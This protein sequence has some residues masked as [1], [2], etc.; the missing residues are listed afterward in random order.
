MADLMKGKRGLIM[1]VANERSIAWA[2][3]KVLAAEGAEL[4]F[5]YQGEGFG[6]RLRPLAESVGSSLVIPAD[7]QDEA[8]LDA[9]FKTLKDEWGTIDFLVHAIAYS[10]KEELAG[11][12]IDT[13]R[14]NFLNSLDISCFSFVDVAK[15]A[16]ALMPDGGSMITLT[17]MG[18]NR[19]Q[20]NYNVMG[21]AKAA[22]ESSVRYLANDLGPDNIRVNAVSPGPMKTLAGAA[23]GGARKVYRTIGEN[24]PLRSNATPDS[25]G[26]AAAFLLSDYGAYT[27]GEIIR[28]DGGYHVMGMMQSENL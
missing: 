9:T 21:V 7:V 25:V 16:A 8:S 28:V 1:G 24:A 2:I 19:V 18:S 27:T 26:G 5:T 10:D 4:A 11:R 22:L 23:I 13:S 20:P 17:Y 12:F 6:K 3:A 14:K 15:R